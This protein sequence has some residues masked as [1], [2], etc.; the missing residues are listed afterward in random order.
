M[1]TLVYNVYQGKQSYNLA[2][3]SAASA[4]K[5]AKIGRE[6]ARELAKTQI[7]RSALE[8]GKQLLELREARKG[9]KATMRTAYNL[10]NA[11]TPSES[12]NIKGGSSGGSKP[13]GLV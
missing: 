7:R 9:H 12:L 11:S 3:K 8:V 5:N 1:V 4:E 2:E 10:G 13:G 6:Q